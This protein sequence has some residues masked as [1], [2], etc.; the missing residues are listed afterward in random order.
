ML[1][2]ILCRCIL[3]SAWNGIEIGGL[4]VEV[5]YVDTDYHFSILRLTGMLE[6]RVTAA[7]EKGVTDPNQPNSSPSPTE[8]EMEGFLKSCLD[9]LHFA[10]CSSSTQLVVTLHSFESLLSNNPNICVLMLDSVSAFYW[11][12]KLAGGNSVP[13]QEANMKRIATVVNKLA[14]L[15]NLVVFAAK[16]ALYQP[17]KHAQ[18]WG[19]SNAQYTPVKEHGCE[20]HEYLCKLWQRLVTHRFLFTRDPIPGDGNLETFVMRFHIKQDHPATSHNLCFTIREDGIQFL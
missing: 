5:L 8:E 4:G 13:T 18:P 12:D 17:R 20:H 16:Q 11:T 19:E 15:H 14:T 1:L 3:P 9:R 6:A 10:C 2:H 7:L